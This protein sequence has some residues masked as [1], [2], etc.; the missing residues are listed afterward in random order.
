V[1]DAVE[2]RF[3]ASE[4]EIFFPDEVWKQNF[5]SKLRPFG[6]HYCTDLAICGSTGDFFDSIDPKQ[7]IAPN[8]RERSSSRSR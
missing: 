3:W 2:K 7:H 8:S 6:F 4:R 1:T 5:D